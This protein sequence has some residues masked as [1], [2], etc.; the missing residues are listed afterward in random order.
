MSLEL[1]SRATEMILALLYRCSL[2]NDDD[3]LDYE[4]RRICVYK[5]ANDSHRFLKQ[6]LILMIQRSILL[7]EKD[8]QDIFALGKSLVFS[9]YEYPGLIVPM[10]VEAFPHLTQEPSLL[11]ITLVVEGQYLQPAEVWPQLYVSFVPCN[12]CTTVETITVK[13][14]GSQFGEFGAF[15]SAWVPPRR[16]KAERGD[17]TEYVVEKF[18]IGS[19]HFDK[20][21]AVELRFVLGDPK[22]DGR[23]LVRPPTAPG[24]EWV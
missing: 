19:K 4:L 2:G 16:G 5:L 8:V 1:S 3:R 24:K 21:L 20:Q 18:H 23:M 15:S 13:R 6:R 10:I 9:G 22:T 17:T 7:N 11:D 12:A 14:T